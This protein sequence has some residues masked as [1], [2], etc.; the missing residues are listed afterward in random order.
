MGLIGEYRKCPKCGSELL[1]WEAPLSL[2]LYEFREECPDCGF[3]REL[4]SQWRL[5]DEELEA[6]H[7]HFSDIGWIRSGIIKKPP[8]LQGK[9]VVRFSDPSI[10][11]DLEIDWFKPEEISTDLHRV[12]TFPKM[13]REERE[14]RCLP[15]KICTANY[16]RLEMNDAEAKRMCEE[17]TEITDDPERDL[18]EYYKKN[19]KT[20]TL[21]DED[22]MDMPTE[23]LPGIPQRLM[24]EMKDLAMKIA[25]KVK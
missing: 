23:G 9:Y 8:A 11:P 15:R 7:F 4:T 16:G 22:L 19:H 14:E 12:P 24:D 25:R 21:E 17:G 1:D 20:S 6:M 5:S 18:L 10:V 2:I 13:S 3:F